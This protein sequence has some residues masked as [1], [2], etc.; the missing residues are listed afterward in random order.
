MALK[1]N[2]L[3]K[4]YGQDLEPLLRKLYIEERKTMREIG[5]A[6]G[7]DA[8]AIYYRLKKFGIPTRNRYD[9]PVSDKVRAN[10][11][12]LGKRRKGSKQSAETKKKLSDLRKGKM[13]KPS[14]YGGHSKDR[15]GY[16]YVYCPEHPHSSA[17]GYVMEHRLVMESYIGR[18]LEKDEAV[19]HIN[20]N[21][22]DNRLENLQLMTRSEHAKLHAQIKHKKRIG[23]SI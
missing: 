17:D 4:K 13:R 2:F 10:A 3:T 9:H 8:V 14:K 5:D 19:H 16:V 21:K 20:R 12:Q 18:Y 22:K 1:S 23:E 7:V 6:L 15:Y 11:T